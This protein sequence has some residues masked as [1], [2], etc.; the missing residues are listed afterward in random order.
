M[1]NTLT[2]A[3]LLVIIGCSLKGQAMGQYND[4][5]TPAEKK[6]IVH[7]GTEPAF[8]GEY[9]NHHEKGVYTCKR[10]GAPLFSSDAKFDSG[11]GWPSFDDAIPGAVAEVPDADGVRTEIQCAK[12]GAHLGHVF[13]GEDFTGKDTRHC[14]NSLSLNFAGLAK[15]E[16][17]IF[18]GGCFWGVEY[19][20]KQVPGVLSTTVG[21]VGGTKDGPTYAEVCAKG[22][23]HAEAVEVL[24]DASKVSYETLARL[25]FEIHDPTQV[26]RQG[27][28]IG[29]QYR[30][31]IFYRSEEQQQVAKKLIRLLE[32]KGY[33]VATQVVKAGRFWPAEEYHQDYY[34]RTGKK[35][36]CHV[37]T[38]RF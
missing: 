15:V 35:P 26:D 7:K 36:Y 9:H 17:A 13:C 30:S 31:A 22:T 5:L 28:D 24:Y 29:D 16:R 21:Y 4:S 6:V 8:S 3:S 1:R 18:A 12:C 32:H 11:T 34:T 27:P 2:I 23:G 14:V 19:Y 20:F 33:K 38:K 10:C 25:F 37:R